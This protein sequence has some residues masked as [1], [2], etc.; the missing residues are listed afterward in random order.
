MSVLGFAMPEGNYH[1]WGV[2]GVH[3]HRALAEMTELVFGLGMVTPI[4]VPFP[5]LQACQ[6]AN[7]LPMFPGLRSTTRNVLYA[8]VEDTVAVREAAPSAAARGDHFVAGSTWCAQVLRD[9]GLRNVSTIPQGVH[10]TV[11]HPMPRVS[12]RDK[13]VVF[14]GGKFEHRKAQ[15]VVIRAVR[16]LM[17]KHD[18]VFLAPLWW[19]PF[20]QTMDS[21]RQSVLIK[22]PP[23]NGDVIQFLHAVLHENGIPLDRVI[24]VAQPVANGWQ[25]ADLM[26]QTDVGLFPNRAEGGTNLVMMEMLACGRP[27][28]AS[29]ATGHVDVLE[30]FPTMKP[31]TLTQSGI[32]AMPGWFEPNLDETIEALEDAYDAGGPALDTYSTYRSHI[33]AE[34]FSWEGAARQFLEVCGIEPAPSC[35]LQADNAN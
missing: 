16:H 27:V 35:Q 15:D 8:F 19:N 21:M 24:P 32:P 30:Q 31:F 25:V 34:H 4:Q 33:M 9:A 12:N 14:S 22:T 1:G 7:L 5:L 2:A 29:Y 13:F 28:I 10:A 20:P 26:C 3:L 6:G 23:R 18:D 11:F 17:E